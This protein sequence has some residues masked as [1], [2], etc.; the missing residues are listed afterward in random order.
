M[1]AFASG[2]EKWL[3]LASKCIVCAAKEEDED[4]DGMSVS[5]IAKNLVYM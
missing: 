2:W 3:L 4:A 5:S 1:R